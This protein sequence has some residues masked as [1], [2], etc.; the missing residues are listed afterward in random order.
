MDQS[1]KNLREAARDCAQGAG[2][3]EEMWLALLIRDAEVGHLPCIKTWIEGRGMV[4]GGVSYVRQP[5]EWRVL[6]S[7]LQVW[8][9]EKSSEPGS[10]LGTTSQLEAASSEPARRLAM[11]RELGGDANKLRGEWKFMGTTALVAR[12]K[13]D[14]RKRTD[15][16]TIR[17]D[18]KEAAQAELDAKKAGFG[19]GKSFQ[20]SLFLPFE[21]PLPQ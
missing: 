20:N 3:D 2:D 9:K 7:D 21:F 6:K 8:I 12:E 15:A 1:F 17:G 5:E 18:L 10:P 4:P 13:A 11:L 19:D 14:G 16:K